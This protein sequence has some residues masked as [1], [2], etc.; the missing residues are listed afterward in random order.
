M[1]ASPKE[2]SDEAPGSAPSRAVTPAQVVAACTAE[3]E[4]GQYSGADLADIY[5]DRGLGYRDGGEPTNAIADY[6]EA[7]SLDPSSVS[8]LVNRGT[9]FVD[10]GEY[11]RALADVDRALQLEPKNLLRKVRAGARRS[12]S[13]YRAYTG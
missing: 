12:H 2:S 5:N 7:L 8:A 13:R 1:P 11:D 3:I 4:S 9:A 10:L 6:N